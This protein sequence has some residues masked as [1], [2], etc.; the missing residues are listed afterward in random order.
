MSPMRRRDE[1][2]R[3]RKVV[4]SE[5][6]TGSDVASP[7]CEL[8]RALARRFARA[9][10]V[11]QKAGARVGRTE[12]AQERGELALELRHSGF[13]LRDGTRICGPDRRAGVRSSPGAACARC[14]CA[15]GSSRASCRPVEALCGDVEAGALAASRLQTATRARAAPRSAPGGDGAR[16]DAP[17]ELDIDGERSQIGAE[18][19]AAL[20]ALEGCTDVVAYYADR[21]R[22]SAP[23]TC[24]CQEVRDRLRGG[25]AAGAARRGPGARP[26]PAPGAGSAD[27][28]SLRDE[29]LGYVV[30]SRARPP[31]R[32]LAARVLMALGAVGIRACS[33]A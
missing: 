18:L 20:A 32:V 14:A 28:A 12:A 2:V 6:L 22:S 21:C 8:A 23:P 13:A 17:P 26:A 25:A 16:L 30:S 3:L 9:P 7:L 31:S 15:P 33:S 24:S 29:M 1:P 4:M 11:P 27:A 5:A 10:R 19:T